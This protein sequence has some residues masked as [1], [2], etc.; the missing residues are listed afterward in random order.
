MEQF[1]KEVFHLQRRIFSL[2]QKG[3]RKQMHQIQK[4]LINSFSA[5]CI[6]VAQVTEKNAGKE[7][8]G[9]DGE[10]SL[11]DKRKLA[12]AQTLKLNQ[13]IDP[14]K[15]VWIPKRGKSEL[16]PLG[17]PTIQ[18]RALQSLIALALE[19]EWEARFT[20]AMFGFRKGRS[21]HDAIITIRSSIQFSPKF[22]LDADIEKFFDR[23]DHQAL[24]GKLD[25]F[26]QMRDAILRI[27]KSGILEGNVITNPEEGT[28]QGGPLS[29]ILANI[30][31]CGLETD[32]INECREW[33]MPDGRKPNGMPILA[34]YADDFVVLH[35]D[36]ETVER[37]REFI[38]AWLSK[39][40]L[41]L[42]P[43]KTRICHTLNGSNGKTGFNFL[44]HR[45]EQFHT[46]KYAVK[47]AFK[48]VVTLIQP[49]PEAQ[50]RVYQNIAAVIK[51]LSGPPAPQQSVSSEELMINRLNPIIRGW[52]NYFRHCNAKR[53]F[54]R[55]DHILWWKLWKTIRR[56]HKGEGRE[57]TIE[58]YF[59]KPGGIWQF[60]C[61]TGPD[62]DVKVL[63]S[64]DETAIARHIAVEKHRRFYDGDWAY[65]GARQGK[66]PSI[67][68]KLS[69]LLKAQR[70]KCPRCQRMIR[71][72]DQLHIQKREA[73]KGNRRWRYDVL[74]HANCDNVLRRLNGE[75]Q[76]AAI[77]VAGS[78]VR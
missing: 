72:H 70:G 25:T 31:L 29:P 8:A 33:R 10:R 13:R 4:L 32:L 64:F 73:C 56:R 58:K 6:A 59:K 1:Q 19:P 16:R 45:I 46:G 69:G 53:V 51:T 50:N 75:G 2:S 30:V 5:K 78:P 15:R 57:R 62:S 7:T 12:L 35:R 9:V 49:S 11:S 65:W 34:M 41:N 55:L 24:L 28:P 27:L 47:A 68:A 77:D 74:V 14:V 18:D 52:A 26:P 43:E 60:G 44:G 40:G 21:A 61:P 39:M 63:R 37:C 36:Y 3:N 20:P 48:Q 54:N 38:S 22:V 67:P 23:V 42:H 17:I 76:P 66:Y 71:R